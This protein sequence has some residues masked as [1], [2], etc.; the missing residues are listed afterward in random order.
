M[1]DGKEIKHPAVFPYEIPYRHILSWSNENDTVLDPFMDSVTTGVAC[2][3]T[4]RN[5]VGFEMNT[6][7]FKLAQHKLNNNI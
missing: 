4:N 2:K 6:N 7:Y 5:F 1:I 3:N